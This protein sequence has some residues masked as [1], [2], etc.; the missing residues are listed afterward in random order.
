MDPPD[1]IPIQDNMCLP[2]LKLNIEIDDIGF[3]GQRVDRDGQV[4]FY[5]YKH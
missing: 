2:N 5:Y 4:D 1:D 3:S